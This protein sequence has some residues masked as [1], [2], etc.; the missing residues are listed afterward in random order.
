VST[1]GPTGSARAADAV[2]PHRVAAAVEGCRDVV[3]LSGGAIGEVATYLPG[4]LVRGVRVRDEEVLVHVVARYGPPIAE[5]AAQVRAA[6]APLAGG[7]RVDVG[8]DD[9]EGEGTSSGAPTAAGPRT[10]GAAAAT[11]TTAT[12][13]TATGTTATGTTATGTTATGSR[14]TARP[15]RRSAP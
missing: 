2:D 5:V 12:G 11:G 8:I 14:R 1:A 15:P 13:T 3:R 10:G 4:G 6:V 9:L 7:R